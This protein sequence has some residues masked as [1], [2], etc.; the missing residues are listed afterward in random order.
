MSERNMNNYGILETTEDGAKV[1]V[2]RDAERDTE[3]KVAPEVGNIA[4]AMTVHGKPVL[5]SPYASAGE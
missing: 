5:W 4:T 1:Y 2:L 3:V